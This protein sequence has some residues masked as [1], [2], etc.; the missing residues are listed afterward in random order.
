MVETYIE[1]ILAVLIGIFIGLYRVG[2]KLDNL[3]NRIE[4]IESIDGEDIKRMLKESE[5]E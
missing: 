4:Y 5:N 2:K 3:E 1:I